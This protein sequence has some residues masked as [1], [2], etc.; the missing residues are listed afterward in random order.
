MMPTVS[1]RWLTAWT[2]VMVTASGAGQTSRSCLKVLLACLVQCSACASP[3]GQPAG[4]RN[5]GHEPAVI[6]PAPSFRLVELTARLPLPT[7][8]D[9]VE[10]YDPAHGRLVTFP[11]HDAPPSDGPKPRHQPV[12][13]PFPRQVW[14]ARVGDAGVSVFRA[15][16]EL[17][18]ELRFGSYWARAAFDPAGSHLY[19][20]GPFET[21]ATYVTSVADD[22]R[23]GP[24][25]ATT[26]LP[27]SPKGRRSLHQVFLAGGRLYSLGG[28][29]SDGVPG[30]RDIHS[31]AVEPDGTIGAFARLEVELPFDA[32]AFS[33]ARC[34][35]AHVLVARGTRIW[36]SALQQGGGLTP[37]AAVFEDERLEHESYGGTA[38]ACSDEWLVL[39]DEARTH[40][41]DREKG[42]ALHYT[43]GIA[44]PASFKRRTAF[45]HDGRFF[46]T[47][48]RGGTIYTLRRTS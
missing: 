22:G 38:M 4:P 48:T 40:V 2:S 39:V 9:R 16:T 13:D 29:H 20:T 17:P 41:F 3:A 31:A 10:A 36:S 25:R 23:L 46:I 19:L 26:L 45:C 34:G 33:L 44:H 14:S 30:L 11:G 15:E 27:S 47:T 5:T 8:D 32:M 18:Q 21:R 12:E 35:G 7:A 37:F 1:L 6:P 28:W 43:A 24:W 42:G